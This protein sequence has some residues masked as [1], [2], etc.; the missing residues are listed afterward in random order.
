MQSIP[1]TPTMAGRPLGFGAGFV[2]QFRLLWTSRRP[3]ILA[4]AL[5]ALLVLAG[6]P[7]SHD[8]KTRLL[9]F[10]PIWLVLVGPVWAFAVFHNEGPSK[11]LYLWSLPVNRLQHTLARLT[12]GLVWLWIMYLIL[13]LAGIG[14][15]ALDGDLWQLGEVSVAGWVNLFTGPLMGYLLV[16]VLTVA[17]DFPIR[18]FFGIIFL[19]PLT[20]SVL[21]D[22]LGLDAL[23]EQI[24]KPLSAPDW[25]LFPV[26]IGA[27]FESVARL[28]HTL[29]V[30]ADPDFS[31]PVHVT[32]VDH[33]WLAAPFWILLAAGLVV[34]LASRHPDTLPRI[35]RWK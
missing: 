27:L 15:A 10:S 1:R 12:A 4:V 3:F 18:W 30:M 5:L 23:V 25:G 26:M 35:R 33:W 22:W 24:L 17:S 9:T 34:A 31:Q 8:P 2:R 21:A 28:D 11:R 16:S 13:I 6:E 19:F 7:W 29:R 32:S 20:L 14:M